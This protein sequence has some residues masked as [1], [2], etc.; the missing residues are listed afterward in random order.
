[1]AEECWKVKNRREKLQKFALGVCL[2]MLG[3]F[4]LAMLTACGTMGGPKSENAQGGVV[5]VNPSLFCDLE[6]QAPIFALVMTI[7][8]EEA[9]A[10]VESKS[11]KG[12][13]QVDG[14][15][16]IKR[17]WPRYLTGIGT[18]VL[19][20]K[21]EDN[22]FD[23]FGWIDSKDEPQPIYSV[24]IAA[25]ATGHNTAHAAGTGSRISIKDAPPYDHLYVTDGGV[26]EVDFD[27]EKA[28]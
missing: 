24:P 17:N 20:D 2:L 11:K 4:V 18:F 21:L 12:F 15:G 28:K 3:M 7:E 16:H 14:I 25:S 6:L 22:D 23:A 13:L 5:K 10:E 9:A 27:T 19:A 1:M 26:I 8:D